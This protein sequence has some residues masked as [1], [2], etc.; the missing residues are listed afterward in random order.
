MISKIVRGFK[1]CH[2]SFQFYL[3]HFDDEIN[4]IDNFG[5][6]KLPFLYHTFWEH[7]GF[8]AWANRDL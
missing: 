2:C 4:P 8:D 1:L 7:L 6:P 3:M 5:K